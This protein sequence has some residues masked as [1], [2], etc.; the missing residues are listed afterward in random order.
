MIAIHA[1]L[2]THLDDGVDDDDI[3]ELNDETSSDSLCKLL[4]RLRQS[5]LCDTS[6]LTLFIIDF[7]CITFKQGLY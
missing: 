6:D 7:L 4:G 1:Q 5:R 2:P 3:E